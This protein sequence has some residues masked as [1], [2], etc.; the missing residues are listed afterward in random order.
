MSARDGATLLGYG[1][2]CLFGVILIAHG[3][4]YASVAALVFAVSALTV[5]CMV[6]VALVLLGT[7]RRQTRLFIGWFGPRG[8]PAAEL[9]LSV[10]PVVRGGPAGI[11]TGR[12]NRRPNRTRTGGRP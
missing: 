10:S 9:Q 7:Q 11:G 3:G 6:P 2:W 5:L 1:V 8:G 12:T 4:G